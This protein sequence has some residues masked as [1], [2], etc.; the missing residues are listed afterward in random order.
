MGHVGSAVGRLFEQCP[1]T[2]QSLLKTLSLVV[3]LLL[4]P[5]C[6][7]VRARPRD[8]SSQ[9]LALVN[10][11]LKEGVVEGA[12]GILAWLFILNLLEAQLLDQSLPVAQ[13]LLL[14]VGEA[15]LVELDLSALDLCDGELPLLLQDLRLGLQKSV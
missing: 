9:F 14:L 12:L 6:D 7:Y 3:P 4:H 11:R 15:L 1:T 2:C 13:V 10:P 8:A 5:L